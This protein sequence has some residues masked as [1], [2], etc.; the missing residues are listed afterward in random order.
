MKQHYPESVLNVSRLDPALDALIPARPALQ[1]LATGFTWTEGPV[2]LPGG[3]VV[4][5]DIPA[6]TIHRWSPQNGVTIFLQPSGCLGHAPFTGPEP[7]SNGM[8][9]DPAG[10]LTIAGHGQRN[11]YRLEEIAGTEQRTILADRFEGKRFNS[12][13]D[14]VYHSDG[15]LYFTDPIYGLQTQSDTDPD[16]DLPVNGVYRL[17][18]ASR[19]KPGAS[20]ANDHLQLLISDLPRPNGIAFSPDKQFLYVSNSEPEM[21]WM[22][23]AVHAGGTLSDPLRICHAGTFA[24][25]GAPDGLKL[26]C[27]GN[28]Y[29]A[30]P[31]GIW[32]MNA[33]GRHLGT[34][35]TPE[36]VSNLTWGGPD[37]K[38]L[39]VTATTSLY[40]INL[41]VAGDPPHLP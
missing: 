15:S 10:R 22:R 35:E 33:D 9:L 13:N 3:D 17:A 34:L 21:F 8:T 26:D 27:Q 6:N 30:G 20:P 16:K 14:L 36:N 4:F 18:G 39:Y 11:L 38:T 1:Q 37:R 31:G 2:W 5:A 12:P 32:I 25:R 7:G 23:Y 40:R 29:A 28:L 24:F 19:H 41:K